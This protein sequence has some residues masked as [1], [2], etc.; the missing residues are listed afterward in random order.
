MMAQNMTRFTL[1]IVLLGG[2]LAMAIFRPQ[3]LPLPPTTPGEGGGQNGI[4]D[5]SLN[6]GSEPSGDDLSH[7]DLLAWKEELD[8]R[9]AE[10]D[11]REEELADRANE[12][13]LLEEK[14]S[15]R[16][17]LLSE[18]ES[19][20]AGELAAVRAEESQLAQERDA[21]DAE[22]ADLAREWE[23]LRAQRASLDADRVSLEA[24]RASLREIAESLRAKETDLAEREHTVEGQLRWSV[25]ALAGSGLLAV[26]SIMVL[27]AMARHGWRLPGERADRARAP[28]A[29]HGEPVAQR[30]G[31]PRVTVPPTYGGNGRNKASVGHRT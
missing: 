17:S 16:T 12:L 7:K 30:G 15:A 6:R 29:H 11:R 9:E 5:V 14:L 2:L 4:V 21:L 26:P 31:L 3:I 27:V 22:K 19:D 24:D 13:R 25:A 1:V 10:L 18:K 28:Q 8:G 23:D 20:L